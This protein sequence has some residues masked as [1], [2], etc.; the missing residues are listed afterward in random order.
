MTALVPRGRD[1]V[2]VAVGTVALVVAAVWRFGVSWELPAYVYLA[3]ITTPLAVIDLRTLRLP[4]AVTLSA[5]PIVAV[6]LAIPAIASGSWPPYGRAAAA[7][8]ALLAF[9]VVLHLVNPSGMG[10]GDVKLS[11]A[12]GALL[13]WLSW[14][15]LLLGALLG[16]VLAAVTGLALMVAGRA[17][18]KTALPF[19]PFMLVGAWVAILLRP[20]VG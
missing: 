12:L 13:G 17:G 7:G 9:Y 15:A 5:Y 16:F 3:V 14:S 4:N 19:G 10:M 6:L 18:R 20:A 1:R 8:A 11:G 2:V